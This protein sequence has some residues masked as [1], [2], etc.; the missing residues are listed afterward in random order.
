MSET[1]HN[2]ETETLAAE[3]ETLI[4]AHAERTHFESAAERHG[5]AVEAAQTARHEATTTNQFEQFQAAETAAAAPTRHMIDSELK[6]VT[7]RRELQH[8]R[9][10]L[11]KYARPFSKLVHQP[12][13]RTV[14]E[15]AGKTVS[16]PSGL[17]GGGLLAFIGTSSYLY[18]AKH[19]GFQYNSG[20]FVLLFVTG[21]VLGLGLELLVH[22]A[23]KSRRIDS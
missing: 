16:R 21:F 15:A 7:L 23:T 9:R 6:S 3:H 1:L 11:P 2:F 8:V 5:K 4:P 13:I 14:S 18:L 20:V 10:R 19:I 12:V 22:I 17:L